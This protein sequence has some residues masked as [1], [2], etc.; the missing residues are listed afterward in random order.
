[1]RDRVL[2]ELRR[3]EPQYDVRILLAVESG[4]R[5]WGFASPDSDYDVRFIYTHNP[6]WYLSVFEARDVI[7]EMLPDQLDFSGWELRKALRL[8]SKCNLALNEWLGSPITYSEVPDFRRQLFNLIPHYFNPIAAIHHYR[9]M[10][11]RAFAENLVDDHISIK[12][13][14]YVLRPLLACRWIER[15]ASQP[16]TEFQELLLA[17]GVSA[18]ERQWIKHLLEQK[19]T[20]A[21]AHLL[22]LDQRR[23]DSIRSELRRYET[24]ETLVQAPERKRAVELN[25]VLRQWI[26]KR[27]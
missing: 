15:T 3:I 2:Q 14:F 6:D 20:A 27:Q 4:S 23:I 13:I 11:D 19:S 24:A 10:A 16:P 1:M 12:K 9:S 17:D 7:E 5:A 26:E 22:Q 21:E 25:A 8:F 18:D